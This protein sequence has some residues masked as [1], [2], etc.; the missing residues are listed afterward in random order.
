MQRALETFSKFRARRAYFQALQDIIHLHFQRGIIAL[1]EHGPQT[2]L[3]AGFDF[4][5]PTFRKR[6]CNGS[7]TMTRHLD[8]FAVEYTRALRA[9]L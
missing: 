2:V 3:R 6:G 5:L 7:E 4:V 8:H 1:S 9:C